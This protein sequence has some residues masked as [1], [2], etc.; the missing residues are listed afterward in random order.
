MTAPVKSSSHPTLPHRVQELRQQV[1]SALPAYLDLPNGCPADLREALSYTLLAP[2]KRFRPLLTLLSAETCGGS[3]EAALPAACAVEMIHSY[4][5]VH[6][7]LPAMDDDDFRRGQPTCHKRFG[8]GLAILTG[9]A[10][11]T[12]AFEVLATRVQPA[13]VAA[14]CCGIL[15]QAAGAC[16]LVGGQADD[17]APQ[18]AEWNLARLESIHRRKTGALILSAVQLGAATAQATSE[19]T[20]ALRIYGEQI[21]LA[22]QIADDLLDV[23]G[24]AETPGSEA[25]RDEDLG[26]L[27]FPAL[28]GMQASYIRL[29]NLVQK[30]SE[31]LTAFGPRAACLQALAQ[32]V[33][34]R[35]TNVIQ[36]RQPW[37]LPQPIAS[38]TPGAAA[39][40]TISTRQE[41][42]NPA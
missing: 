4:S 16:N 7:D 39:V 11:L 15:A 19:Q 22:F 18:S 28:L 42:P 32:N 29:R 25:H 30:A 35:T 12:L 6:D 13:E 23:V 8:E 34:A 2:G 1:D 3:L 27:T 41:V 38:L 14:R 33:L 40:I 37:N 17:I 10:L 24:D 26:K 20:A 9:D 21:G 31:S 5:L 36:A